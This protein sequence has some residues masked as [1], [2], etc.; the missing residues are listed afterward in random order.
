[1][2]R[3]FPSVGTLS[4]VMS[5]LLWFGKGGEIVRIFRKKLVATVG[6][7]TVVFGSRVTMG[8]WWYELSK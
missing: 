6:S 1:M 8:K 7:V 5:S 3:I 2:G 4:S